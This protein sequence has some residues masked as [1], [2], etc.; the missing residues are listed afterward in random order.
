M[1]GG[2]FY[3]PKRG[4]DVGWDGEESEWNDGDDKWVCVASDAEAQERRSEQ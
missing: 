2:L 1:L 3:L 4:E